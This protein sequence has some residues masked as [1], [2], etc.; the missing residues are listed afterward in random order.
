V[1]TA[2]ADISIVLA[3]A[4][5]LDEL[6][7][8]WESLSDHHIEVAPRLRKLG[9]VRK[10]ADSWEVRRSH[11]VSL[12]E[13]DPSAFVLI[14]TAATGPVGYALVQVRGP[15]ESW[16][17]GPVAVLETLAV[18]PSHRR[19]G[20]GAALVRAMMAELRGLGIGHWE[21]ATIAANEE[22]RRFYERLDLLP[23]TVNYIGLVPADEDG[24]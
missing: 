10:P 8:L 5:R 19:H 7:P 17:T 15:E 4:E 16:D 6:R 11:Y 13:D 24:A 21:V 20:I 2:G 22:A 18:L 1:R 12:F 3:G 23:F 9:P 14:A